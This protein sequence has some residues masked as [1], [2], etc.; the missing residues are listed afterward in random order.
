MPTGAHIPCAA[1]A[2]RPVAGR[3]RARLRRFLRR[4]DGAV[5]IPAII[6]IPFFLMIMFSSIELSFLSIRHMLL[7]RAVDDVARVLRLGI[8]PL[9]P[10]QDLKRTLCGRVALVPNCMKDLAV[11]VVEIDKTTWS[12]TTAGQR[13]PCVDRSLVTQPD[14]EVERGAANQLMLMR[15]CLKVHPI[16][17][18]FGIGPLLPL[19]SEGTLALVSMTAFVNEP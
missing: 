6:F 10:L 9:P 4:E 12:S 7:E 16:M 5:T 14:T 1:G 17:P 11:E 13:V 18:T 2:R 8:A 19:D 15:A 3:G